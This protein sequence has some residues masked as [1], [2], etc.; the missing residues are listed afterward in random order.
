VK[1]RL[2]LKSK[3]VQAAGDLAARIRNEPQRLL[4][5]AD[6]DLVLF[7]QPPEVEVQGAN[8]QMRFDVPE[9]SARGILQRLAKVTPTPTVAQD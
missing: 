2:I 1:A 5:L 9:N 3:T 6:S 4:K 8:V 7:V